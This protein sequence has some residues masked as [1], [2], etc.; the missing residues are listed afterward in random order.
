MKGTEQNP[1]KVLVLSDADFNRRLTSCFQTAQAA[2][3]A[4]N[5]NHVVFEPIFASNLAEAIEIIR[6]CSPI[7]LLALEVDQKLL[8]ILDLL[9]K[10]TV[11]IYA[12]TTTLVEVPR[13]LLINAQ[14][15]DFARLVAKVINHCLLYLAR[16]KNS[17]AFEAYIKKAPMN[18]DYFGK[19]IAFHNDRVTYSDPS[20][21]ALIARVREETAIGFCDTNGLVYSTPPTD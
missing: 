16:T 12:D 15:I 19:W 20:L 13:A 2:R 7:A 3:N 10:G 18:P 1:Y 14:R 6:T 5:P 9:Y 8:Q 17:E 21:E 4:K 11:I